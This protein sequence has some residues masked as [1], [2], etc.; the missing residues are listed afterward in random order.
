[1]NNQDIKIEINAGGYFFP[2]KV[3]EPKEAINLSNYYHQK[4]KQN[5]T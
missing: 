5:S 2:I 3:L 4:K 1:M